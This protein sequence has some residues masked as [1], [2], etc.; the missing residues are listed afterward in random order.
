[1]KNGFRF[2][3]WMVIY[4][5][6]IGSWNMY[7]YIQ[8][9]KDTGSLFVVGMAIFSITFYVILYYMSQRQSF[10]LTLL[11]LFSDTIAKMIDDARRG[12]YHNTDLI[13]HINM[14]HKYEGD[15]FSNKKIKED[16]HTLSALR[17][18]LFDKN[19][20]N[21]TTVRL[22]DEI[23]KAI[24]KRYIFFKIRHFI[25]THQIRNSFKRRTYNI[26]YCDPRRCGNTAGSLKPDHYNFP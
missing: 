14:F 10:N 26:A 16:M 7:K 19:I 15:M 23:D 13:F 25:I 22:C 5:L 3:L 6:C 20:L 24:A 8:S 11:R 12:V 1:M 18:Y 4:L 21:E 9:P 17:Q 2:M